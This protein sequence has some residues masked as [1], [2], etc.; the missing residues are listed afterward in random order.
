MGGGWVDQAEELVGKSLAGD[1]ES[2]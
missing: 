1:Q 2:K